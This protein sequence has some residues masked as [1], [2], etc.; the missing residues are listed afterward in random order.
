ML[1]VRLLNTSGFTMMELL[2]AMTIAMVILAGVTKT[3]I[4]QAKTYNAQQQINEME[5]NAR[6]VLDVVTR[7]LKMAGYNPNGA[8]FNG[9]TYN[10]TQLLI[11]ADLDASGGISTSST[12]NEQIAY[13]YDGTNKQITRT[14]GV[15]SASVLADNITAFSFSYLDSG[16]A[17]T[18]ISANIRQVAISITAQTA[19]ADP[20]YTSNG[21][22]RT[23]TVTATT[24]PP[25]LAL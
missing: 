16:G 7:D 25:N 20:D 3:F 13:A 1:R 8:T 19:S 24:T 12:A 17:A 21:G 18:I 14:V 2:V 15:G 11:Q 23:Y 5:E 6:G 9:I 10:T 4:L 22:Y